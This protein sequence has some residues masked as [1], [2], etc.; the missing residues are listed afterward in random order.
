MDKLR[1]ILYSHKNWVKFLF[2][3]IH[4]QH[5]NLVKSV[6]LV[7]GQY[8]GVMKGLVDIVSE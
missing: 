7:K 1:E 3:L 4:L 6:Y 5:S 2:N 8:D